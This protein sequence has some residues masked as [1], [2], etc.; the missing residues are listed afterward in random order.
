MKK[1]ITISY[2]TYL[3]LSA[4]STVSS[5]YRLH[6]A[7]AIILCFDYCN[8]L[9]TL[10]LQHFPPN[11]FST[12][13]GM[14][15]LIILIPC[16][17]ILNISLSL[18]GESNT[19]SMIDKFLMIWFLIFSNL[20]SHHSLTYHTQSSKYIKLFVVQCTGW[21]MHPYICKCNSI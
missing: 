11:P 9:L 10:W 7:Q 18:P 17:K 12:L 4:L 16:L 3:Y 19:T 15:I 1:L 6:E 20:S 5:P 2:F 21:F 14:I 13:S 8:S